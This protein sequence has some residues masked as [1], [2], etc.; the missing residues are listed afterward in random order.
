MKSR[1]AIVVTLGSTQTLA[2]SSSYYI[3]GVLATPIA[4]DIGLSSP[5]IYA[6][7]SIGLGVSAILGPMLGRTIDRHGGRLVLC[8]SNI[9]FA[10]GLGSL[11]MATGAKS[12]IAAWLIL[13]IAM[14]AGLYEAAFASL[15][16]LYGYETRSAI[17]GLTMIAGFASTVAWPVTAVL[18]HAFGWRGACLCWAALHIAVGLPLNAWALRYGNARPAAAQPVPRG[19]PKPT[20][21]RPDRGMLLLGFTMLATG[22]VS[23]GISTNLPRFF[24]VIGAAPAAAIAAASLLGPAQV[25]ARIF[26]FAARHRL[27]PLIS[28][29]IASLLHPAAV[30]SV[31]FGGAPLVSAFSI[32]HGAGNGMLTI[33][34]ATLP[35][36]IYGPEGYGARIG[37]IL[38]PARVGQALAPF[39]FGLAIDK[40]GS[41]TLVISSALSL[42]AL[43]ALSWLSIP[44]PEIDEPP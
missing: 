23:N 6:A 11:A 5:W 28:A 27:N 37:R 26:E 42:S 9:V 20:A 36:A 1:I 17:T 43:L 4:K 15:T 16:R 21:G 44:S 13:G 3:P 24:V 29:R 8:A 33:C 38:A 40:L 12:L 32:L 35:L 7:L 19:N 22:I 14:S 41:I 30:V 2:W 25:A 34:R 39:L 18:E 31:A 10:I